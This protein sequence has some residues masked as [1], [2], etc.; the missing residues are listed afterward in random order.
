MNNTEYQRLKRLD[1]EHLWHPFTQH[2]LWFEQEP[3][4][5][6]RAQGVELVDTQGRRYL[7]GVSSLWCNVHGHNV[8]E[9]VQALREQADRV[10]HSTL[11]GLSHPPALDLAALLL[12]AVPQGLKRVFFSDSGTSAVE[13]ALRMAVEWWQR[14]PEG[15]ARARHN[16]AS[17]VEAYHGDTLGSVGVGYVEQFHSV[18]NH[19]LVRARR[20]RP[21]HMF[22]F[23]DNRSLA[24]AEEMSLAELRS[25]FAREARHLAAFI[26]EPLVQG[27]AGMWVHS[28]DFLREVGEL[29]RRHDVILIVD[30]VA[31]GFGKTGTLFAVEQAG[32][33][34][35]ILVLGKGL[36]GGYLPLS[37]AVAQE[38]IFEGFLG[39][40]SD[41]NAL[42]YGQTFAG[43]P[44]AAS[45]AAANLR[46]IET[47]QIM[48]RLPARIDA[49]HRALARRIEPLAHVDEVRKVGLMVGIE[50]TAEPG[51]HRPYDADGRVTWRIVAKARELGA[52]IRPIGNVIVLMPALAME[53]ADLERLVEITAASIESVTRE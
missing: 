31:T 23:Y 25:F 43:N 10:C 11:L 51:A 7:D 21:P 9:L 42:F 1:F 17:L 8:P 13:A 37:A 50:L 22:R 26:I 32:L 16:L 33:T 44:L 30:E 46:L 18:L 47:S 41:G 45:V 19:I 49:L 35:D 48:A 28:A 4:I 53:E 38:R 20:V 12:R 5:V 6:E 29:C 36:T 34:P 15:A 40:P 24:E 3:L 14:Q 27:A 52:V 39:E 2:K